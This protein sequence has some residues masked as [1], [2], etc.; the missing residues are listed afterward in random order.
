MK[1]LHCTEDTIYV[2]PKKE[3]PGLSPISYIHVSVSDLCIPWI[4]SHI[5]LQHNRQTDPGNI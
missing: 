4:G 5:W 1:G 3:L 2:F